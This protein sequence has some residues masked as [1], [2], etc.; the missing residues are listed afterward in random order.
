MR[1]LGR[2]PSYLIVVI[3]ICEVFTKNVVILSSFFCLLPPVIFYFELLLNRIAQISCNIF[4]LFF[5]R[6]LKAFI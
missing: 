4:K 2:L 1:Q 3:V 6:F 5:F